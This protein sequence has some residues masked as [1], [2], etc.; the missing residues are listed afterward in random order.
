MDT[1][2][3]AMKRYHLYLYLGDKPTTVCLENTLAVL[4]ALKLNVEPETNAAHVAIRQWLQQRLDKAGD[5]GRI[6]VSQW[7]QTGFRAVDTFV[8]EWALRN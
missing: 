7:L 1:T 4:M 5:A 6:R 2:L 8:R 3:S